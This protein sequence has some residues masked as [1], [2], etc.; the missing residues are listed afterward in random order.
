MCVL[1]LAP[2]GNDKCLFDILKKPAISFLFI[3]ENILTGPKNDSPL[4][5]RILLLRDFIKPD[6]M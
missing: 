5:F 6:Q 4:Y 2:S 1:K 3:A